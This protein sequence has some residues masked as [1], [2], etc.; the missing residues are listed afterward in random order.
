MTL[1]DTTLPLPT[2]SRKRAL[3]TGWLARRVG[4]HLGFNPTVTLVLQSNFADSTIP[5]F[6]PILAR[7]YKVMLNDLDLV[8]YCQKSYASS[9]ATLTLTSPPLLAL[10]LSSAQ[11]GSSDTRSSILPS[12][13]STWPHRPTRAPGQPTPSGLASSSTIP[14][15]SGLASAVPSTSPVPA[16]YPHPSVIQPA[17]SSIRLDRYIPLPVQSMSL[18]NHTRPATSVSTITTHPPMASSTDLDESDEE[19]RRRARMVQ[20]YAHMLR[21]RGPGHAGHVAP[22]SL[23]A[24]RVG[25]VYG[26]SLSGRSTRTV[27]TTPRHA[28]R[29]AALLLNEPGTLDRVSNTTGLESARVNNIYRSQFAARYTEDDHRR[30]ARLIEDIRRAQASPP[31]ATTNLLNSATEAIH[32]GRRQVGAFGA[33]SRHYILT[34]GEGH[35][36]FSSSSTNEASIV[37]SPSTVDIRALFR[38][39]TVNVYPSGLPAPPAVVVGPAARSHATTSAFHELSDIFRG[40]NVR[41]ERRGAVVAR[42]DLY[43]DDDSEEELPVLI[44][45]EPIHPD[46]SLLHEPDNYQ[47][48]M[49]SRQTNPAATA[50]AAA[51]APAV[52]LIQ[53]PASWDDLGLDDESLLQTPT[54]GWERELNIQASGDLHESHRPQHVR[55]LSGQTD[56][57][58]S[59]VRLRAPAR[60]SADPP[61][62]VFW[63]P[64]LMQSYEEMMRA[65]VMQMKASTDED[66]DDDTYSASKGEQPALTTATFSRST[67]LGSQPLSALQVVA[68]PAATSSP[69]SH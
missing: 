52:N 22:S 24:Y 44:E 21:S 38:P 6:N 35:W 23:D 48:R 3:I 43:D 5:L 66:E 67:S 28:H 36:S 26:T 39:A 49:H 41:V 55:H 14:P 18:G 37:T 65:A 69:P 10:H 47:V 11:N 7:A 25:S 34:D 68:L 33:D 64:E 54:P 56:G 32:R 60:I 29:T 17:V 59:S 15:P 62:P 53:A 20:R 19:T 57:I 63:T 61:P 58:E 45:Q 27:P 12:T 31:T 51:P 13:T 40:R 46:H 30:N 50:V 16:A 1:G 9:L 4:S 8:S 2:R 42:R